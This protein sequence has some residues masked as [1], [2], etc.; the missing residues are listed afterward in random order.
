MA[1][2]L[3]ILLRV[4]IAL[5]VLDAHA[6]GKGLRLHRDARAAQHGE[7]VARTVADR[8][9][10]VLRGECIRSV[11]RRDPQRGEPSVPPLQSGDL[12]REAHLRTEGKQLL[13]QILQ[14]G[15]EPVGA[16]VRLG[17]DEDVLARAERGELL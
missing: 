16:D 17:V 4:H 8:E 10:R 14:N 15:V 11:G 7:G 2:V 6:H 5:A 13:P 1:R 3:L 9:H 12:M